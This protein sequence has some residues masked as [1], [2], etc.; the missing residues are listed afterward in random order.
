LSGATVAFIY[1]YCSR[2]PA[3]FHLIREPGC[4][5]CAARGEYERTTT[6]CVDRGRRAGIPRG[7]D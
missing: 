4:G 3:Q 1:L 2:H 6:H 7:F 5:F